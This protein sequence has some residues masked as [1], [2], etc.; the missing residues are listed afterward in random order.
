MAWVESASPSFR[1]RHESAHADDV[2]RVLYSLERRREYLAQY[3]PRGVDGMSVV[4]HSG[5]ASLS[6]ACPMLPPA[7][8]VAAPAARRYIAGWSGRDELHILRPDALEARASTVPGSLEMLAATASA[9]YARRV[10]IENNP[11]VP[12]RTTSPRRIRAELRWAWLLDGAARWFGGQTAHARPAIARRLREGSR[13]AFPP[14][15]RDAPLLGGTV[16]DLL[17]RE[18]GERAAARL[19]CR[20]HPQGRRAA[21][22]EAFQGRAFGATEEAWRNHLARMAEAGSGPQNS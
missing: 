6:I 17:V 7:W 8:A 10:I 15:V 5:P 1:A 4:F 14:G 13:P 22:R 11:D 16:I 12:P 9:L 19:A 20:L 18:H 21:L 2:D 3:F